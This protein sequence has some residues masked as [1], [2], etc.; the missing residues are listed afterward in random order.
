[1][2]RDRMVQPQMDRKWSRTSLYF[3]ST[4]KEPVHYHRCMMPMAAIAIIETFTLPFVG[5][6]I[7]FYRDRVP[8][9]LQIMMLISPSSGRRIAFCVRCTKWTIIA[10]PLGWNGSLRALYSICCDMRCMDRC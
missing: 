8:L 9:L 4:L 5:I 2:C 3:T 10:C 1:M 7:I 6:V